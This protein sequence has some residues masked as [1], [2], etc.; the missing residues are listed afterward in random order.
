MTSAVFVSL[1]TVMS[2]LCPVSGSE[3]KIT[4]PAMSDMTWLQKPVVLCFPDHR[5]GIPRQDQHGARKPSTRTAPGG[6]GSGGRGHLSPRL[7]QNPY[8]NLSIHTALVIL[9]LRP[10]SASSA[11]SRPSGMVLILAGAVSGAGAGLMPGC[12]RVRGFQVP[13]R[14]VGPVVRALQGGP[15]GGRG[16]RRAGRGRAAA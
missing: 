8:V 3:T 10:E 9:I 1:R 11:R 6:P 2:W 13:G 7:P 12:R 5:P 14:A 16:P 15:A 4:F